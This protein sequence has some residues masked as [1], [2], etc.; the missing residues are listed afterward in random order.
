VL[1]IADAHGVSPAQLRLAWSLAQGA[2]VLAIPGTGNPDHLAENVATG[3]IRLTEDEL[4]RL[5]E[6]HRQAG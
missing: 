4:S 6:L 5:D 2:H 1:A 3:A